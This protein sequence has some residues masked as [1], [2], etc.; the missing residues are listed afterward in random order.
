MGAPVLG[1]GNNGPIRIGQFNDQPEGQRGIEAISPVFEDNCPL[2]T[3]CLAETNNHT[4]PGHRGV[5]SKL[6]GEVG[7]RIVAE[8]FAAMLIHDSQSFVSQ[9][10]KW[11]PY[12]GGGRTFG[13]REFVNFAIGK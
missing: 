12:I 3:Y 9:N 11:R 13:L 10:P 8:T 7:G 4:V 5:K 1:E 6:L 2:W